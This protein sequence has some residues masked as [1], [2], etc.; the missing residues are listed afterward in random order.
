[1]YYVVDFL[2]DLYFLSGGDP[3]QRFLQAQTQ[4]YAFQT[5]YIFKILHLSHLKM[6]DAVEDVGEPAISPV[7]CEEWRRVPLNV[8]QI[9]FPGVLLRY[10][11]LAVSF[12]TRTPPV[13]A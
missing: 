13:G 12:L 4:L 2:S 5:F 11:I 7:E 3:E 9:S 8:I 6:S 10:I 1:M